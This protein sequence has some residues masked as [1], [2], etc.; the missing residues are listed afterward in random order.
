MENLFVYGTLQDPHIQQMIFG[1]L[2]EG[3]P[4]VLINFSKFQVQLGGQFYP[5]IAPTTDS[6]VEGW[7]LRVTPEELQRADV[8]ET[9][10]YQRVR[11]Q[12]SSGIQAWVYQEPA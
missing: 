8:Y 10:D 9:E 2:V 5:M 3:Q 11:V 1:R 4:D 12:L 6:R 7:L